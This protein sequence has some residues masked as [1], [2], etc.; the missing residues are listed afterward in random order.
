MSLLAVLLAVLILGGCAG[1]GYSGNGGK[2][3][4]AADFSSR[5]ALKPAL[6]RLE[7]VGPGGLYQTEESLEKLDVITEYLHQERIPFHVALIPRFVSPQKGY[8]VNITDDSPYMKKFVDTIK[9]MQ[10]RGAIVGVHGYTHQTGN[11]ASGLGFEFFD[12]SK[13]P[14]VPDTY[15]YA[16]SR[17]DAAISLFEKA[18]ITPGFW[19]TPHYTASAKQYRAFEEQ[20]GLLY[21]N[22]HGGEVNHNPKSFDYAGTGY[23][24]FVTVPTPLGYIGGEA[25]AEK[26]L[27]YL[28]RVRD[29]QLAS[30]FYHPFR[31]FNYIHKTRNDKGEVQYTYDQ[32]SPLHNLIRSIRERGYT[33]VS[34]NSL[35]GFVPAHRLSALPFGEGDAVVTGRFGG[36]GKEMILVWNRGGSKWHMYDYTAVSHTPRRIKAFSLR[37]D[38]LNGWAPEE[39]AVLLAGDFNGD[40]RDDLLVFNPGK[41]NFLLARNEGGKLTPQGEE[42]LAV[43]GSKS[44]QPMVGDFNGDGLADLAIHDR[45]NYRIGLAYSTGVGFKQVAWQYIDQL[46]GKGQKIVSGDF[47]GDLKSDVA[48]LDVSSGEW[49]VL[50]VGPSGN[51][52]VSKNPWLANWGAGEGWSA[53]S[54]DV[55]G[56]GR[57]DLV[58]YSRMGR[59]LVAL[60]DGR[61]FEPRLEFGPW[62]AGEKGIPLVADINGDGRSDLLFIEGT[63]AKGYNLDVA[64]S[65]LDR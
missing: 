30:F 12:Q 36:D 49:I 17:I 64:V 33:F 26:M 14:G 55:N 63:K 27:G 1:A 4:E 21:E 60:S 48:V 2:K 42:V 25:S 47:N 19:E 7:D 29:T 43:D 52:A 10:S 58:I 41:G 34:V 53:F 22:F 51:F 20:A 35:V 56:D 39:N 61:I 24:G 6:I 46:K 28:D 11:T 13:N 57:S 38:W 32:N 31:E 65:V 16:R 3:A 62:G 54:A 59:W 37:G 18:G 5:K 45:E 15:E 8:D 50:L 44:L 9:K 40:K 23:R